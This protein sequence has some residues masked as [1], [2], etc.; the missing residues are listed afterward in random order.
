MEATKNKVRIPWIHTKLTHY[1]ADKN[2]NAVWTEVAATQDRWLTFLHYVI[3]VG[4]TA[5]IPWKP[6]MRFKLYDAGGTEQYQSADIMLGLRK[7]GK[8]LDIEICQLGYYARWYETS[9][10]EQLDKNF[11]ESLEIETGY[12]ECILFAGETILFQVKNSGIVSPAV[13]LASTIL[14]F[15]IEII[16]DS[17]LKAVL[18]PSMPAVSAREV[19]TIQ[20]TQEI[21]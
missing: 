10:L 5:R 16:T 18:K 17:D 11:R 15:D 14:E 1:I 21:Q 12:N 2:L 7:V 3:P 9:W 20:E 6:I 8:A 19:Q 13:C 4:M